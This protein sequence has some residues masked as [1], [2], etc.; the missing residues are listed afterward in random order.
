MSAVSPAMQDDY[1]QRAT[2]VTSRTAPRAALVVSAAYAWR[3]G[4]T[5]RSRLSFQAP[6][7]RA[8]IRSRR[9]RPVRHPIAPRARARDGMLDLDAFFQQT[10]CASFRRLGG[11]VAQ[12]QAGATA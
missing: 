5:T 2:C 1:R 9:H 4:D 12:R 8:S 10:D 7:P 11:N 3:A 6:R